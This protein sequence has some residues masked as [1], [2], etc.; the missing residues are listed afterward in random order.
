MRCSKSAV[1]AARLS[2]VAVVGNEVG[3]AGAGAADLARGAEGD[4]AV[5]HVGRGDALEGVQVEDEAGDVGGGHGGA[6]DGVGGGVGADPRG[7]DV[8]ATRQFSFGLEVSF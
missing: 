4:D 2:A 1:L 3:A 6:R 8:A 7:E 5:A